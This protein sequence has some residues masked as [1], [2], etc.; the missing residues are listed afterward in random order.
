MIKINHASWIPVSQTHLPPPHPPQGMSLWY[1]N[2]KIC[3]FLIEVE[4][5]EHST[6]FEILLLV[7]AAL[8]PMGDLRKFPS[9]LFRQWLHPKSLNCISNILSLKKLSIPADNISWYIP[10]PINTKT[11]YCYILF[12]HNLLLHN[13]NILESLDWIL[14]IFFIFSPCITLYPLIKVCWRKVAFMANG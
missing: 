4:T 8:P 6:L 3:M 14:I 12:R 1:W 13:F 7:E 10:Q 2:M 5:L 11:L 9:L